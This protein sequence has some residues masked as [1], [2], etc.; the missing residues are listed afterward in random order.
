M[1]NALSIDVE[2]YFQV[3]AFSRVID[4]A[5]WST[6][7]CRVAENTRRVLRLLETH[8][9]RATF[10]VLGWV[11]EREPE[12]VREIAAAGHEIATHG[13]GH[14]LIY[15]QTP[16]EFA[17]DVRRSIQAIGDALP[18]AKILGYRAPSFSITLQSLWA[19]DILAGLGIRYDSSIFPMSGHDLYGIPDAPRFAHRVRPQLCEF[20]VSTVRYA[21]R[22]WPVAGG[23][24]F[25]LF[26][27]PL[28]RYA[29]RRINSEH[30]PAVVYLH[31]WEFDPEQP[32]IHQASMK[33]RFRHYLNLHKTETRLHRLLGHFRFAPLREVFASHLANP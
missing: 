30:Q 18:D 6:F 24:Y 17:E 25:R 16:E 5:E 28:T 23:G 9:V 22:N 13:Y 15:R 31:P 32:R 33:S 14:Q 19:L 2:D 10:F 26:P 3:E 4:R 11:A 21:R 27:L 7:P 1:L 20:P 8:Q 12:L 29:I